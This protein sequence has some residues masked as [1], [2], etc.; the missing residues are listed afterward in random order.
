[1]TPPRRVR[2]HA[3]PPPAATE[4]TSD[5]RPAT[6]SGR[7]LFVTDVVPS[8]PTALSP[9]HFTAPVARTAQ[10][11]RPLAEMAVTTGTLGAA[12]V[13]AASA[14]ASRVARTATSARNRDVLMA[15]AACHDDRPMSI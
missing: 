2:A 12:V 11:N 13:T 4:V 8:W 6:S 5:G 3:W 7:A 10:V 9:Q 15:I 14:S 1:M